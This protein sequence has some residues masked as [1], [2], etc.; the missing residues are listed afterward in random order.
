MMEIPRRLHNKLHWHI[1]LLVLGVMALSRIARTSAF[2]LKRLRIRGSSTIRI[3]DDSM[4]D[5]HANNI[6]IGPHRSIFSLGKGR[7]ACES[8]RSIF[9]LAS[10]RGQS[11]DTHRPITSES[12]PQLIKAGSTVQEAYDFGIQ[13]LRDASVSEPEASMP[14]LLAIALDLDWETGYRR[15]LQPPLL[16]QAL[17][18]EQATTLSQFLQRRLNH[19]PIQYI[20]GQWDFL[21]YVVSIRPP[22]LCP[23]PETEELVQLAI[24]DAKNSILSNQLKILDIGCGTGVIGISLVDQLDGAK[25]QAIDIEPIAVKTSMENAKRI[26]RGK[27]DRYQCALIP[28]AEYCLKENEKP[29]DMIVSNPPYIPTSDYKDLSPDVINFESR[30]A[31]EAGEDGLEVIRDII[32]SMRRLCKPGAPCW[33]EVDPTHPKLMEE[34]LSS[35]DVATESGVVFVASHKDMFGKDRFVELRYIGDQEDVAKS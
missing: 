34:M 33:M 4:M 32:K 3:L 35:S 20:L 30:D 17:N 27:A 6:P 16:M 31:L 19:E 2:C 7:N 24:Q 12:S 14:Q 15:V 28:V 13:A 21:D 22:L 5:A 10:S 25:V 9:S 29:F 11:D 18:D 1:L 23:R 8:T 26:L